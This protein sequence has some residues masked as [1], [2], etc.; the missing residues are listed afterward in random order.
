MS[1]L[2]QHIIQL[3]VTE[4]KMLSFLLVCLLDTLFKQPSHKIT[5]M[6]K[7]DLLG[8]FANHQIDAQGS[9]QDS[10]PHPF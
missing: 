2:S 1:A 3:R 8:D 5:A 4:E 6:A 7:E 10:P 9:E